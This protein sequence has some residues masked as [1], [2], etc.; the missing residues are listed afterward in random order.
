MKLIW[1]ENRHSLFFEYRRRTIASV[2]RF[3]GRSDS[4]RNMAER[5]SAAN[6][7]FAKIRLPPIKLATGPVIAK[8][9]DDRSALASVND[10]PRIVANEGKLRKMTEGAKKRREYVSNINDLHKHNLKMENK[11]YEKLL[12]VLDAE[13]AK[14]VQPVKNCLQDLRA[15]KFYLERKKV[16]M[17]AETEMQRGIFGSFGLIGKFERRDEMSKLRNEYEPSKV[18]M[19]QVNRLKER[20]KQDGRISDNATVMKNFYAM[21]NRP[22]RSPIRPKPKVVVAEAKHKRDFRLPPLAA[23]VQNDKGYGNY[24]SSGPV[25][26]VLEK[27]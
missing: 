23:V 20:G 24:F 15:T 27:R 1:C 4:S 13:Y 17:K 10:I 8:C 7:N 18:R 16:S 26:L 22:F 6:G 2:C 25:R 5:S 11:R 19:R 14:E 12:R 21:M 3:T 9:E